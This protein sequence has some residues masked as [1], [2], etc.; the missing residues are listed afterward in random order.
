MLTM[1]NDGRSIL[2]PDISPLEL[3][4][5][6]EVRY[7][8]GSED[9]QRLSTL[10]AKSWAA[11]GVDWIVSA[12]DLKFADECILNRDPCLD[13]VIAE[14]NGE[15]VGC[16]EVSWSCS[17]ER[18]R[19]YRHYTYV[20]PELRHTRL[21]RILLGWC[22]R[23]LGILSEGHPHSVPGYLEVWT[24]DDEND[25]RNLL[26]NEGYTPRKY[27]HEMVRSNL[28]D[29]PESHLPEGVEIRRVLPP[30]YRMIWDAEKNSMRDTLDFDEDSYSEKRFEHWQKEPDFQPHLWQVAWFKDEIV[31]MVLSYIDENENREFHRGRGHTEHICVAPS[32]RRLGIASA[33]LASGLQNLKEYGMTA[34]SLTVDVENPSKASRIYERAGFKVERR[35]VFL[36]KP[37]C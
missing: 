7:F 5:G 3:P 37:L 26:E 6:I 22:E 27:V 24:R 25:L 1:M 30:H 21:R 2:N 14:A 34:A 16:G 13:V 18:P 11:D 36:W 23:R 35:F 31:G 19:A 15:M 4:H 33:L 28:D 20:V 10:M 8:R 9:Y 32:W 29:L 17:R 12:A